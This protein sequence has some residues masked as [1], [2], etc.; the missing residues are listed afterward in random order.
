M[1]IEAGNLLD[2]INQTESSFERAKAT[3]D[4]SE[5]IKVKKADS[6]EHAARKEQA[7][8]DKEELKEKSAMK[9]FQE[10]MAGQLSAADRREQM[11]ILANTLSPKDYKKLQED[12]YLDSD[13]DSEG[14]ITVVDKIKV[15]LAKAGV[16]VSKLGDG[17]SKEQL[18]IV[19]GSITA[20]NQLQKSFSGMDIP[21]TEAN[22]SEGMD[23][24]TQAKELTPLSD[25]AMKYMLDNRLEPTIAN[26]YMAEFSSSTAYEAP[27]DLQIDFESLQQQIEQVI[28]ASGATVCEQTIADSRWMIQSEILYT[29][30]NFSYM[31]KLRGLQLPAEDK[32]IADAIALAVA[33]GERPAEAML[34]KE[35]T[36]TA[37]AEYAVKIVTE[38]V[39]EDFAY[40]VANDI[41]LSVES[42]EQA[43]ELRKQGNLPLEESHRI[44]QSA[45]AVEAYQN[46]E[47]TEPLP[48]VMDQGFAFIHS[49]RVLQEACLIMTAEANIALLKKGISIDIKPLEQVVEQLKEQER[50]YYT[51][52]LGQAEGELFEET[53]QKVSDLKEMPAYVLGMRSYD[54]ETVKGLHEAGTVLQD[55]MKK[56]GESYETLMTAPRK[57]LGDSIQKAFANVDDILIDLGMETTEENQRAVRIL[58]Y[59]RLSITEE[60][61]LTMKQADERVQRTFANLTPA[62]VREMVKQGLNPLDMNLDELNAKAQEIHMQNTDTENEKFSEYLWKLEQKHDISQEEREAYIGI[63][64]LLHQIEKSD[65]AAIGALVSQGAE[66]TMR[67]LLTAVRSNKKNGMDYTVDDTFMGVEQ[68]EGYTNSITEQIETAY[69]T[70]C[71]KDVMDTLTPQNLEKILENPQWEEYTPEQLKAALAQ[72]AAELEAAETETDNAYI[73]YRLEE[74]KQAAE[75]D[76]TVYKLLER[77]DLPNTVNHV[78]AANRLVSKRNQIFNQ[79]FNAEETFSGEAVD[80]AGIKE[81]ILKRFVHALKTPKEMAAAQ[82]TLAET[83]ENIMKTMIADEEHITSMDI[84][85]LKLMYTQCS[86]IGNMAK[87]ETYN[88]PVMVGD[89]VANMSLRIVRGTKKR[90][91][92]EIMFE[93]M[94]AGKVAACIAAKENGIDGL[95]AADNREMKDKLEEGKGVLADAFGEDATVNVVFEKQL[96]FVKFSQNT[97]AEEEDGEEENTDYEIQTSRLYKIAR[98][99]LNVVK[100]LEV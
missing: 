90:G 69:Q 42:L 73:K 16:D 13:M 77:F 87:D 64:R 68:A 51:K 80:F 98:S 4:F 10:K 14:I 95:V 91:M 44:M 88:I 97:Y 84:R 85:E 59:N 100:E 74:F 83:A 35:Y 60:S 46:G 65:G 12:G 99:F 34:L 52:L 71:M 29:V 26:L 25:G 3:T 27:V 56:A 23:A 79:L 70:D 72:Y 62:T 2:K 45:Q 8:Y 24:F 22:L 20:A 7:G 6:M 82:E 41:E 43:A 21:A 9:E 94:K 18:E 53:N 54:L 81:E 37:R 75:A 57:D 32:Q 96:N 47:Q 39:E 93:T 1:K 40:L 86:I 78:L 48:E 67:N 50:Q 17:L 76:E 61:V 19:A 66:I 36:L 30:D 5:V 31:Q 28:S 15:Q 49:K 38:A 11:S 33:E 63:Y 89:E 92:V 58:A 55:I